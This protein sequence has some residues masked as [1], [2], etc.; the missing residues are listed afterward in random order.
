MSRFRRHIGLWSSCALFFFLT[1]YSFFYV[2][3]Y[4]CMCV[5]GTQIE[6]RG[7]LV[8]ICFFPLYGLSGTR[9]GME[10]SSERRGVWE[11]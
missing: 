4:M 8:E 3:I 9:L 10:R 6:L 11:W 7:Q 2:C 1:F 5:A